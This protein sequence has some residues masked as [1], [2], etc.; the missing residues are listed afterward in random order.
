MILQKR[1]E[2]IGD[3]DYIMRTTCCSCPA[4]CGVKVFLKDSSIVGIYGD[5]EHPTN[6][7]SLC[8]KGLLISNHVNNPKRIRH[9]QV[10]D[11]LGKPFRRVTWDEAISFTTRRLRKVVQTYGKRSVFVY[12]REGSPFDYLGAGTLFAKYLGIPNIP[13]RFF[14]VP[15]GN[16]GDV[17]TM[18]GVKGS[19][20]LMNSVRDW[21][22]SKC[23][24]LYGC[25]LAASS[26]ITFGPI[27][28]AKDHGP[29]I[30]KLLVIDSKKTQT[31][32]KASLFLRV[33][34]GS[35]AV[36]LKGI[37]NYL[38]NK[39]LVDENFLREATVDFS[40]LRSELKQF[41]LTTV[42]DY[43]GAN[44]ELLEKMAEIIGRSKPIQV[45]AGDAS[46]RHYLSDEDL[47]MCGALVCARGSVGIPGGGLNLLNVCPFSFENFFVGDERTLSTEEDK[48][49]PEPFMHEKP[50]DLSSP[51]SLENILLSTTQKVGALV[52]HGNPCARMADGKRTKA[53][54]GKI[55]LIVHLS[56]Y[57]NETF[58]Y[59]HISF[60]VS[61][62]LEYSGLVANSNNRNL[63]WHHKVVEP[64][65]E[66]KSPL[67][68]WTDLTRAYTTETEFVA[69]EPHKLLPW[70]KEDG[71]AVP[72]K[73]MEFFLKQSALTRAASIERLDPEKNPPGGLLWPC[74][75]K[76][77]LEFEE[78]RFI[79]A[80]QGNVRGRNILFQRRQNYPLSSNRFPTPS[81]KIEFF[82]SSKKEKLDSG[83]LSENVYRHSFSQHTLFPLVLITGELVDFVE[84]FGYFV[85]D[86]GEPTARM[87][88]QVHPQIGKLLKVKN[89]EMITVENERGSLTAPIWFTE[90]VDP[91]IIWCPEGIDPYQPY[92]DSQS[93]RSLFEVPDSGLESSPFTMVT[94]Y[95]QNQDKVKS[96]QDLVKFLESLES[97]F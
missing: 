31:A 16:S 72:H 10:R 61:S 73:A 26:P 90:D 65:G 43:S 44:I 82:N 41:R 49:Y 59:S 60:P 35:Q 92:F 78:S 53:H 75:E 25:D 34:P 33:R 83:S 80:R 95:K 62:W 79:I 93:P 74:I 55:P 67:D 28:D 76:R 23:I 13:S 27:V 69:L 19:Q 51:L 32:S 11:D 17:K 9:P 8:P 12:G 39:G 68:F 84:E 1:Q 14:P 77:D 54:L 70:K 48:S 58:H 7:G 22:N 29:F 18:F 87:M 85:S 6:K 94:I 91:R 46:S 3:Y 66:C 21:S 2:P 86:R 42:A 57:P 81:G 89:G 52:W 63:Q 5:E 56:S 64:P 24:L 96:T 36:V 88:V 50:P 15:F 45:I 97:A 38:F 40:R 30:T 47:F 71:S 20:L 37:M 4:G